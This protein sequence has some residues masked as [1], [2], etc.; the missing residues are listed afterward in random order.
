MSTAEAIRE[1]L[2]ATFCKEVAVQQR[3]SGTAVSLPIV[4]RDGDHITAYV[5]EVTG[6]WRVSDMGSTL[7]RLSYEHDLTTL[8]RGARERLF[9]SILQECGLQEDDGDIFIEVAASELTRGL[10]ALGQGIARVED[11]SLWTRGRVENT[12]NDDLRRIIVDAAGLEK[13]V[14]NYEL[15]NLPGAENYPIDFFVKTPSEPLFIFGI[16]NKDKARLATIVLQH[17]MKHVAR[18]NSMVVYSDIDEIARP[19]QKRLMLAANDAIPSISESASIKA[20]IQHR[21]AA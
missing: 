11:L 19:D 21:L 5:K 20:K 9:D 15:P 14:E 13:V 18:F 12:F 8:L 1:H 16:S 4:G 17:L 7:M 2:C 6:G 3:S 10:F